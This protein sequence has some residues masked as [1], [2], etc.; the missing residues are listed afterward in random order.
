MYL[1]PNNPNNYY[2]LDIE[3]D[4]YVASRIWCVVVKNLETGEVRHFTDKESFL[5]F[6]QGHHRYIGHY[7]LTFDIPTLNRLWDTRIIVTGKQIGRAHV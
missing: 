2:V 1:K 3:A 6:H 5:S 7:L 4:D